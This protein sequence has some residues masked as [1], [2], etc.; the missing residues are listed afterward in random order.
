MNPQLG[1]TNHL[2]EITNTDFSESSEATTHAND[3]DWI[4]PIISFNYW[5]KSR[6]R[7]ILLL[8]LSHASISTI[9]KENGYR[10]KNN[11]SGNTKNEIPL[12][13]FSRNRWNEGPKLTLAHLLLY[14]IWSEG[15]ID[16]GGGSCSSY[17][18]VFFPT[19]R[20]EGRVSLW[21]IWNFIASIAPFFY[22]FQSLPF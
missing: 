18:V 6:F 12:F 13:S 21:G 3:R 10:G 2:G 4:E 9:Q 19:T 1:Q 17:F 11:K 22:R 5:I 16:F 7:H 8:N 20:E 15:R 14:L